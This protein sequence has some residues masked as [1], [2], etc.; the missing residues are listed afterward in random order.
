[1][2]TQLEQLLVRI[3]ATTEGLRRELRRAEQSVSATQGVI[4]RA[5]A[6]M[7]KAFTGIGATIRREL[8]GSL[9]LVGGAM[10]TQKLIAYTDQWKQLDGRLR[11]VTKSQ[12][13]YNFVQGELIKLADQSRAPLDGTINLY[14]RLSM[15]MTGNKEAMKNLF[16]VTEAISKGLAITGENA[17]A[18][19]GAVVQFAQGLATNFSAAGQEIRSIQEQAP[20]VAKAIAD[21]LNELGITTDATAANLN[22]LAKDGVL[23]MQNVTAAL[24]TQLGVLREEFDKTPKTVSQALTQLD[25]AFLKM[26]GMSDVAT[27]GSNSLAFSI[28]KLAQN[29]ELVTDVAKAAAIGIGAF[30][31]PAIIKS[32]Q[33]M[34]TATRAAI[35]LQASIAAVAGIS[36]TAQLAG[37]AM[38]AV[39]SP[40]GLA[41]TAAGVAMLYF[42][43][44][45][46]SAEESAKKHKTALE[47]LEEAKRRLK[48]ET[49]SAADIT[50]REAEQHIKNAEAALEEAKAQAKLLEA[51]IANNMVDAYALAKLGMTPEKDQARKDLEVKRKEI[52]QFTAALTDARAALEKFKQ[53]NGSSDIGA[54]G[55]PGVSA[56][57]VKRQKEYREGLTRQIEQLQRLKAANDNNHESYERLKISIDAENEA[58]ERGYKIGTKEFEQVKQAIIQRDQL[59]KGIDD[60][61]KAYEDQKKKAEE[62]QKKF[63]EAL[64]QPWQHAFENVQDELANMLEEGKFSFDSLAKIAKRLAAEVAAAWI[65]RPVLGSVLGASGFA[66]SGATGAAGGGGGFDISSLGNLSSLGNILSSGSLGQPLFSSGSMIGGGIDSIGNLLGIGN[67]SFIGPMQAGQVAPLSGAFTGGAALASLGGVLAAQLLGLG[68]GVGGSIGGGL[69]GLVGT[70]FG[71]PIGGFIGSFAGSALGGLFGNNKPS[72]KLQGGNISLAGGDPFDYYG[73]TGKKF[74]QEN[75]D[76]ATGLLKVG[77]AI[78]QAVSSATG[79]AIKENLRVEVGARNGIGVAI[80][81]AAL[82]NYGTTGEALKALTL[83]IADLGDQTSQAVKDIRTAAEK[84]DFTDAEKA[85]QDLAFA[86]NYDGLGQLAPTLSLVQQTVKAMRKEFDEAEAT[87]KRLGLAVEKLTAFE[88]QRMG[89]LLRGY[90]QAMSRSVLE[91]IAPTRLAVL[92]EQKRYMDQLTDLKALNAGAKD[93]QTAELVHQLR[94]QQIMQEN[95]GLADAALETE[96]KRL[97]TATDLSRRFAA[98]AETFKN[99]LFEIQYGK[100][101]ADTPVDNLANMRALVQDLGNKALGGDADAAEQLS[102]LLPAFLDLSGEVN[103]FN[104]AFAADRALAESLARASLSASERQVMLQNQIAASAQKQIEVLQS[105]FAALDKALKDLGSKLTVQDVINSAAGVTGNMLRPGETAETI[106]GVFNTLNNL[107]ETTIRALK[108]SVGF[109]FSAPANAGVSFAQWVQSGHAAAGAK[110]NEL[111]AA[112]GG[113]PQQFAAGGYVRGASGVDKIKAQLTDREFVT[114]AASVKAIGVENMQYMNAM[115]RMPGN[116]NSGMEMRLD[117]VISAVRTLAYVTAKSG[118]MTNE[119]LSAMNSSLN[120][121]GRDARLVAS[122]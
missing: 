90:T 67:S 23:T 61:T 39:F 107:P 72:S 51:K 108:T 91:M 83:G 12:G 35:A 102:E 52:E 66:G 63:A 88:K 47:N 60:T 22:K 20:R 89:E 119:Q 93:Y 32:V 25:N 37:T 116:D 117:G 121:L 14:S 19:Q 122:A 80:G 56:D 8:V 13:E 92:D 65:I 10:A 105:G 62:D 41:I 30:Y 3:D 73:L 18:A 50:K 96:Q 84:I 9:A 7:D 53:E 36:T 59:K 5:S 42:R 28:G 76:S 113:T 69:G 4:D 16:P 71:G 109:D 97:D 40:L 70:A 64:M 82:Q 49:E 120:D 15:A 24:A 99:I 118:T 104:T 44:S 55:G 33:G 79:K 38:A 46:E 103:G 81:D 45:T 68:G 21:G 114:R 77:Q 74:S 27:K 29:L 1:M 6:R 112:A 86:A 95:N 11:V 54:S 2:T 111:V 85:L 57:G 110:F 17:Q 78:A 94:M 115:G 100:Y 87:A 58:R 98:V 26:L 31:T 34:I 48:G 106:G 43:N 101:A 75:K